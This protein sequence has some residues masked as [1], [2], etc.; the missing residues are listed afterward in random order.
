MLC[1][2]WGAA[3][4][5]VLGSLLVQGWAAGVLKVFLRSQVPVWQCACRVVSS[6]EFSRVW[7]S[8]ITGQGIYRFCRKLC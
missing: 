8:S 4:A 2:L 3:V 1:C 5:A 7:C 6:H